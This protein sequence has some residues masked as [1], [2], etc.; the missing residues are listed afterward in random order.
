[1]RLLSF[2]GPVMGVTDIRTALHFDGHFV[3][4]SVTHLLLHANIR[5]VR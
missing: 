3:M 1:M 4:Y 5:I 2:T